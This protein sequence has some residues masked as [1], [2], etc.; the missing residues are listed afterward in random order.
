MDVQ[1]VAALG[2][3]TNR[4]EVFGQPAPPRL[5]LVCLPTT[6][7]GQRSPNPLLD[8]AQNLKKA[9]SVRTWCRT[10]RMDPLLT[11]TVPPGSPLPPADALTHCIEALRTSLLIRQWTST[12]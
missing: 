11:L 3:G 10:Q 1:V 9:L 5:F 7:H 12:R 8:E 6:G 2:R 4:P